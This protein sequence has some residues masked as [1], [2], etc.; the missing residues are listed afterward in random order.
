[1]GDITLKEL[2]DL[3][4]RYKIGYS[5]ESAM[6]SSIEKILVAN[7][8][9]YEREKRLSSKSIIDFYVN[10][11]GIECKVSGNPLRINR[12]LERYAKFDEIKG[13]ILFT[14]IFMYAKT[15]KPTE[16]INAGA[17]WL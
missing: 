8:I 17:A 4:K 9:P 10:G 12:Q 14:A 15:D 6:Q 11:I 5:T 16:T 1:M 13:L 3:L 7:N 2:V